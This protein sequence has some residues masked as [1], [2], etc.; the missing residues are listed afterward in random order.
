MWFKQILELYKRE[1]ILSGPLF[2]NES[3]Q[4][5]VLFLE[6]DVPFHALLREIQKKFPNVISDDTKIE[7]E[8][9]MYRSLTRRAASEAQ[10]AGIPTEVI[11][12]NN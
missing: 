9:S 10:N 4:R 8:F 11:E 2:I 1:G 7:K 6:I 12:A 5:R 3:E